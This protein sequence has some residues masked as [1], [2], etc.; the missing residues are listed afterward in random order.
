MKNYIKKTLKSI[1][2]W[3]LIFIFYS[4]YSEIAKR[5]FG[6]VI[7]VDRFIVFYLLY[8]YVNETF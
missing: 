2:I 6:L 1:G 7:P 8:V 4:V 3:L 5:F